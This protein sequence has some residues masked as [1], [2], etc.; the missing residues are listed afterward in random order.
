MKENEK[1]T[2]NMKLI[3]LTKTLKMPLEASKNLFEPNFLFPP[4]LECQP[5][6]MGTSGS[7]FPSNHF[8]HSPSSSLCPHRPPCVICFL[9]IQVL[10]SLLKD[11]HLNHFLTECLLHWLK[12]SRCSITGTEKT[13]NE[14]RIEGILP[15]LLWL[16][17]ELATSC[18]A[19]TKAQ[20]LEPINN[21]FFCVLL[22]CIF[23]H[24]FLS[25]WTVLWIGP[26][27]EVSLQLCLIYY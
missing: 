27:Q 5:L 15:E 10:A 7:C 1:D 21:P 8:V 14:G 25:L 17:P 18:T 26:V 9:S 3:G 24:I 16:L 2:N 11:T 4:Q 6:C 23:S 20:W 19:P 12:P 13:L 22:F